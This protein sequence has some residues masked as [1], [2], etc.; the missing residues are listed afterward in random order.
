MAK[1]RLFDLTTGREL[2]AEEKQMTIAN[3]IATAIHVEPDDPVVLD[4]SPHVQ[5]LRNEIT[6]LKK[7]NEDL[8]SDIAHALTEAKKYDPDYPWS[9]GTASEISW[10]LGQSS[11]GVRAANDSWRQYTK[12]LEETIH[13]LIGWGDYDQQVIGSNSW[14]TVRSKALA[15]MQTE[16]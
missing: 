2:L 13:E 6:N 1:I 12:K 4:V 3:G 7:E 16:Q 15:L 9:L 14:P 11:L 8:K 10:A 5:A